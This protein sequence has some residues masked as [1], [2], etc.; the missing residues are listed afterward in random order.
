[1]RRIPK[2]FCASASE[3]RPYSEIPGPKIWPIVGSIPWI[4]QLNSRW[5]GKKVDILNM[6]DQ[7]KVIHEK[8]GPVVKLGIPGYGKGISGEMLNIYDPREFMK[9]L[10]KQPKYP[11]GVLEFLSP[12]GN[13]YER[14]NMPTSG[15]WRHGEEWWRIRQQMQK[16]FTGPKD[17]RKYIAGIA[18]AARLAVRGAEH[19]APDK[20]MFYL[21]LSAFDMINSTLTGRL[22]KTSDPSTPTLSGDIDFVRENIQANEEVVS[23]ALSPLEKIIELMGIESSKVKAIRNYT[24]KFSDINKAHVA[25]LRGRWEK[26][27]LNELEESSYAVAFFQRDQDI[28]LTEEEIAEI[29]GILTFAGMDT[30]ATLLSWLLINLGQNPEKQEKLRQEILDVLGPEE[31]ISSKMQFNKELPYLSACI[32]ESF[33]LNAGVV[34]AVGKVATD[35]LVICG[36]HVPVG[37]VMALQNV[38]YNVCDDLVD[39]P[40]E[41]KP[42]RFLPDAVA[43]RK[44]TDKELLDHPLLANGFSSGARRCPGARV[45]NLEMIAFMTDFIRM[46]NIEID[47]SISFE[48][49][50]ELTQVPFPKPQPK[51]TKLDSPLHVSLETLQL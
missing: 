36:Y 26:G 8:W 28:D 9:V 51:L 2:R 27:E 13:S 48:A 34:S 16:N 20:F 50:V 22:T 23:I 45:A 33:R 38:P 47:P 43:A 15:L 46:W 19:H 37:T 11:R 29:I 35:D 32:R 10:D 25:E 14:L 31:S 21:N 3:P 49:R 40:L 7:Q 12:I 24:K 6:P 4:S 30:T 18:H 17:A 5:T 1:M 42:E 39:E 41:F 44:G